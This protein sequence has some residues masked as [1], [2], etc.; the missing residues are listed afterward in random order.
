M[1][2]HERQKPRSRRERATCSP[3]APQLWIA[4]RYKDHPALLVWHAS[5]EYNGGDCHCDLCNAWFHQW[6][7]ERYGNDIGKL[8]HAY[9]S[10]FWSHAF[11]DFDYVIPTDKGIHG[12]MS[13]KL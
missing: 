11:P 12:L 8:N 10:S 4:E 9:W 2:A 1:R 3:V 13:R 7:R 6:L 5:N